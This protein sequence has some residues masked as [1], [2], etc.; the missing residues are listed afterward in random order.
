MSVKEKK[1]KVAFD[2]QQINDVLKD[3]LNAPLPSDILG[4]D[5]AGRVFLNGQLLTD[6]ELSKLQGEVKVFQDMRLFQV[7]LGTPRDVA[8]KVMF[9]KAQNWDDMRS[10]KMLLYALDLQMKVM[11]TIARGKVS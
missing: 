4:G 3:L 1:T 9:E 11:H 6:A 8:M 2:Q 10:G 5:S 7:L